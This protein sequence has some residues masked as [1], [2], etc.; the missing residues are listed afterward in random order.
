VCL[1]LLLLAVLPASHSSPQDAIGIPSLSLEALEADE[2]ATE[3]GGGAV[4]SRGLEIVAPALSLWAIFGV[5]HRLS[6]P[7]PLRRRVGPSALVEHGQTTVCEFVPD[8]TEI[9]TAF[10]NTS[11][12]R[13]EHD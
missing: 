10:F 5:G 7:L 6:A 12:A 2:R 9:S 4:P 8:F 1:L 11:R 3:S 13:Q